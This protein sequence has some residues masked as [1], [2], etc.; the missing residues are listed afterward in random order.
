MSFSVGE[1]VRHKSVPPGVY[2]VR[3]LGLSACPCSQEGCLSLLIKDP[4]T[5]EPDFVCSQEFVLV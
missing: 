5:D 2:D 4:E 1:V 3:V